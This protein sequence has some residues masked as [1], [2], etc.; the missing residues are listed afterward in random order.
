MRLIQH[1]LL[2]Q[3]IRQPDHTARPQHRA[4]NSPASIRQRR[5]RQLHLVVVGVTAKGPIASPERPIH[6]NIKLVL[7]VRVIRRARVVVRRCRIGRRRKARQQSL[8][9]RIERHIDHVIGKLLPHKLSTHRLRRRR[10]EDLRD[11]GK[12]SLPLRS[13]SG[14]SRCAS[15]RSTAS[16]PGSRQRRIACRE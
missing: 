12:N 16:R 8:R 11:A 6:A 3:H 9:R 13:S 10:V 2:S 15:R 7:M 5:Y 1:R 4:R 14:W